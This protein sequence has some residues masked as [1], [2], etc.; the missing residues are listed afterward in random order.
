[1]APTFPVDNVPEPRISY[2]SLTH[3]TAFET[4]L[5]IRQYFLDT[6]PTVDQPGGPGIVIQ[7]Q[8]FSGHVLFAA[9]VGAGPVVGP[10][11]WGWVK[12]KFETVKKSGISSWGLRER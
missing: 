5:A 9:A 2:T 1:M 10:S 6:Y 3:H 7:I 12:G 8:L 11:N 4:G